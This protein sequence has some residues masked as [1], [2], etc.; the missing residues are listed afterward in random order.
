MPGEELPSYRQ[1]KKLEFW[2]AQA[3]LALPSHSRK[4][5]EAGVRSATA[6]AGTAASVKTG[7][8]Y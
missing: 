7:N 4:H 5:P 1:G 8:P 3:R 2:A 6:P